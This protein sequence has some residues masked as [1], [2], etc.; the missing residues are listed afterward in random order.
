VAE[1]VTIGE[2]I[3]E[4]RQSKNYSQGTLALKLDIHRNHVS[5]WETDKCEPSITYCIAL[6]DIFGVTLEELCCREAK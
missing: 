6:A 4:L 1:Q 2:K 3:K 5:L